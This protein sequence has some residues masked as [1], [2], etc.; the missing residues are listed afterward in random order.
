[1]LTREHNDP[2]QVHDKNARVFRILCAFLI[3]KKIPENEH[4]QKNLNVCG[5][6]N[7]FLV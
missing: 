2:E 4:W 3:K 6:N 1:M 5:Q 7:N